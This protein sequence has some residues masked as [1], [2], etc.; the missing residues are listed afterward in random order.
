MNQT[1]HR[2]RKL[3][4]WSVVLLGINGVIGSGIFLL[5]NKAMD[6][7]GPASL[8]VL[9]F[10]MCLVLAIEF[11]FAEAACLF[12]DNGGPYL[13]AKKAFGDFVGYEVGFLTWVNRIVAYSVAGVGFATALSGVVPGTDS[14][15]MKDIIV[16]VIFGTLAVVNLLGIKLYEIIQNVATLA[17]LVP[18]ALFIGCG[19]FFID[20]ANFVPLFPHDSY[21]PG[22]FGTAAVLLFFTFVGFESFSV[23][24]GEMENPQKN[25]PRATLISIGVVSAIY[26]LLLACSIGILG[27]HLADTSTPVEAAFGH[28][29]G[30]FGITVV[31][32]GTLISTASLSIFASFV[33]PTSGL[34]LAEQGMLP[35]FMKR[36]NRFGA[37]YWAI[38]IST[39]FT[40]LIAYTG[41]FAF[42]AAI[43]VVVRFAQ[44][45]PTCLAIPVFR[46]TMPDVH[47]EF[48]VPF[49][50]VIPIGAVAV[51]LWLIS[52]A[53]REQLLMGGAAVLIAVPFYYFVRK[54]P[55]RA[56]EQA[57]T[58]AAA[59]KR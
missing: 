15:L 41:G 51:S 36:R 5:P 37:P 33:A 57:D 19:F 26:V 49:G 18:F 56:M 47:R 21:T 28:I 39:L 40:M 25:L 27:Y 17:K 44:Y 52:Q 6:I 45:I 22:S 10:D 4:F 38:L 58:N 30:N 59:S 29:A 23:A 12:K 34:A 46:K 35:S 24:A 54:Q 32:A 1:K 13:Y 2:E 16:T 3:G 43:S 31:A 42:L 55:G 8:L 14:P 20:P 53:S 48:R 11:C 7:I 50:P 9:L